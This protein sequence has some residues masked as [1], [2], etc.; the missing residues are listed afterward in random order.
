MNPDNPV[1]REAIQKGLSPNVLFIDIEN[2]WCKG[3]F[4]RG[5]KQIISGDQIERMARVICLCYVW[6]NDKK[7]HTLYWDSKGN[8]KKLIQD[9]VKLAEKADLII[10]HNGERHDVNILR[11][12]M[13]VHKIDPVPIDVIDDTLKLVYRKFNFP[14]NSLNYLCQELK[15]G[16]KAKPPN[17]LECWEILDREPGNEKALKSMAKYCMHDVIG[18]LRPLW[19]RL[20]PHTGSGINV[21]TFRYLDGVRVAICPIPL[22]GGTLWF[23]SNRHTKAGAYKRY[24]CKKCGHLA[25][26]RKNLIKRPTDLP[27]L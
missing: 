11:A 21:N 7:G 14:N 13:L 2:S 17:G 15:I 26:D 12:R 23:H 27:R 25:C 22:C 3:W 16:T 5:G 19:K 10:G 4:W 9:F 20:V 24:R 1:I 18:L 6:N 8:D